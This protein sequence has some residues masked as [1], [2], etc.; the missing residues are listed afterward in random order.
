MGNCLMD[1]TARDK[2]RVNF[3]IEYIFQVGIII[4]GLFLSSIALTSILYQRK[5][6]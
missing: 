6:M 5:T 4:V 1:F 2:N 3:P